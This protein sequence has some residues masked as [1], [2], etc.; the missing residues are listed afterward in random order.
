MFRF[1]IPRG[2]DFW[3]WPPVMLTL[4]IIAVG[5]AVSSSRVSFRAWGIAGERRA[6]EERIRRLE[7]ENK[8]LEESLRALGSSEIVERMAKEKLNL[9][10]PGEEVVVVTPP[11]AAASAFPRGENFFLKFLPGWISQF[12]AF[13]SR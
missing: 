2:R 3:G 10:Q 1:K 9:K 11:A 8:R 13:L 4:A 6:M 5:L 7:D 12:I